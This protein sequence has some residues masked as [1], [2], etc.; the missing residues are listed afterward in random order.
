MTH[1]GA[2]EVQVFLPRTYAVH[3]ACLIR[4]FMNEA[5]YF[6]LQMNAVNAVNFASLLFCGVNLLF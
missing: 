3:S 4:E 6:Q 5:R 2:Q 1:L